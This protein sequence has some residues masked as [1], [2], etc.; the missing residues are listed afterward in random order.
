MKQIAKIATI[1]SLVASLGLAYSAN[2]DLD[3][4]YTGF[5][6]AKKVGV[7]GTFKDIKLNSTANAKFADFAKSLSVEIDGNKV[8]TKLPMRDK[9]VAIIF[10]KS[11]AI[12]A[13]I[14]GVKG[15]DTKGVFDMKIT[16]GGMSK[17]INFDYT[18]DAA[19][20]IMAKG[21][22]DI[23]TFGMGE[24][25]GA[26]AKKCAGFHAGK[27]WSEVEMEFTLPIKK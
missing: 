17:N 10:S 24:T 25:F 18:V 22:L 6:T 19:K 4:K 9:N 23:L 11:P 12:K 16:M 5:K 26:F 27:T 2:G 3:L 13:E 15:D 20:G 7:K 1:C 8:D 14:V 21:K